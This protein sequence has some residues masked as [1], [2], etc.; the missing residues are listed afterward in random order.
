MQLASLPA[1]EEERPPALNKRARGCRRQ[2]TT[3]ASMREQNRGATRGDPTAQWGGGRAR[4]EACSSRAPR[5]GDD[6]DNRTLGF[7]VGGERGTRRERNKR[8]FQG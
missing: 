2:A 1:M 5:E 7:G 8:T 3:V 6:G 4:R